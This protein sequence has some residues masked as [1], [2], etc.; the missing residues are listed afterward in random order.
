[1]VPIF[2]TIENTGKEVSSDEDILKILDWL[3][4]FSNGGEG[5]GG[6]VEAVEVLGEEGRVALVDKGVCVK[7]YSEADSK[8]DDVDERIRESSSGLCLVKEFK[9]P[10]N[11]EHP[12]DPH[13]DQ[14]RHLL[15]ARSIKEQICKIC[16]ENAEQVNL[17]NPCFS[18]ICPQHFRILHH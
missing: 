9:H 11:P 14:A 6:P 17:G 15:I 10:V 13:N 12:I 18:I 1:M 3:R 4:G 8:E 2:P 5:E 7:P 16:W